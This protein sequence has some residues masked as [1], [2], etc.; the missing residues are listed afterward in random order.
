MSRARSVANILGSDGSFGSSDI[1][2]ALGYTP[3]NAAN[4]TNVENKSSSTIRGEISSSNVT[5]GLGYTPFNSASAGQLATRNGLVQVQAGIFLSGTFPADTWTEFPN[6]S[7]SSYGS[8]IFLLSFY[9]ST[10]FTGDSYNERYGALVSIGSPF[11]NS[12][13]TDSLT[14]HRAGHAPNTS[15]LQLRTRRTPGATDGNIRLDFYSNQTWNNLTQED[16]RRVFLEVWR[17][18]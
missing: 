9:V 1:T 8:G 2:T 13:A 15:T 10:Y 7:F 4:L 18:T 3:A 17:L 6:F 14:L 11:T 5:T 16:G 12:N